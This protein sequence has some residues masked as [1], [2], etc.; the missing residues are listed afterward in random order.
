MEQEFEDFWKNNE[1]RFHQSQNNDKEIAY[2]AWLEGKRQN[3]K[4]VNVSGCSDCPA[5]DENDMALGYT[6]KLKEHPN[7][8]IDER[9]HTLQP[10]TPEWCPLKNQDIQLKFK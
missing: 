10:I 8:L 5:C 4:A 6:C 7:N 2:S 9:P 3:K 1:T